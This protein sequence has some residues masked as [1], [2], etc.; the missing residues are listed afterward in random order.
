M[1]LFIL[2]MVFLVLVFPGLP[3]RAELVDLEL[4]L[5]VD[6]SGS[7]DDEEAQLQ[8]AGYVAAI[9]DDKVLR[10]IKSGR[11]GRIAVAYVEWA[12]Q[13]ISR[14]VVEWTV[15]D[16][17]DTAADFAERLDF[18]PLRIEL[19]TSISGVIDYGLDLFDLSPHRGKRRVLDISGDGPNNDGGLVTFSRDKA[20]KAGIIINGLAIINGR[21]SR[22]GTLPMPHLDNYYRDCVI[23]GFGAFVVVADTFHDFARAIRRKLVLEIAGLRPKP[24]PRLIPASSDIHP[25]CDMGEIIRDSRESF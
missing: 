5:A 21:P 2:L 23:G 1:R 16:G 12:G 22:Y 6:V 11:L 8:R 10:A 14:T 7:V 4:I 20:V 24:T 13:G 17:A 3:A 15:I 25:P 18:Q 9:T 19:W